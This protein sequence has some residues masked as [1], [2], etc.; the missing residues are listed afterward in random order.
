LCV[1]GV[2][3]HPDFDR[4]RNFSGKTPKDIY[5]EMSKVYVSENQ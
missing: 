3:G 1:D 5:E 4:V 2:E